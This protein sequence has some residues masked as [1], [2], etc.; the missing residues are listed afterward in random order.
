MTTLNRSEFLPISDLCTELDLLLNYERFPLS[1]CDWCGMPT[2]E[3]YSS[4]NLI[5]S[6]LRLHLFYLLR[7]ILFPNLSLFLRTMLFEQPSELSRFCIVH[8]R[9]FPACSQWTYGVDCG[10]NCTC[11]TNHTD[12]C[13]IYNGSCACQ[14]GYEGINCETGHLIYP[15]H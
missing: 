11:D 10:K 4:G 15:L 8:K 12:T 13:D 1:I 3:A 9:Y 6:H 5:P 2:W 7:P 14:I